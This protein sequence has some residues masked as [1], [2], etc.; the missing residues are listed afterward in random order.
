MLHKP[1]VLIYR[2][3]LLPA[4]ETFVQKQAEAL[5]DFIPYYVGSRLVQGLQLPQE[6]RIALNQGGLL[7][8][9]NELSYKLW[10][11][12]S[13]DF[14]RS[15]QRLHPALIHAHFAPDGA[16]ALP[17]AQ[18]LQV[19]LV[20]TFHGYDATMHDKYAKASFWSHR[21]YLRRREVLKQKARLF[22]AVSES[23]KQ[24][25]LE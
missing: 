1:V 3:N 23:I 14:V 10:G 9:T 22:I 17:L 16:I 12:T 2:N 25:L 15:L 21:V 6:R 4:S 11:K 5:R 18:C 19:P 8:L 24:K 13:V 7:G 20:V